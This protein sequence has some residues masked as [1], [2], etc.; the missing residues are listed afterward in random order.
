MCEKYSEISLNH[1]ICTASVP[2]DSCDGFECGNGSECQIF[3]P[4]GEA[5]CNPNCEE[6]NPCEPHE[7]CRLQPVNCGKEPC[8]PL[9]H[10]D[11]EWIRFL[12]K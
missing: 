1:N 11:S 4:T 9:L 2:P 8:P 7:V 5:F 10:C 6:L 3:E 12:M